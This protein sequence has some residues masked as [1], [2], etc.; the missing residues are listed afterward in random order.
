MSQRKPLVLTEELIEVG[1]KATYFEVRRQCPN[2]V[3]PDDAWQEICLKL[4]SQPQMYDSSRG[5]SEATFLKL[6][7]SRAVSKHAEKARRQKRRFRLMEIEDREAPYEEPPKKPIN[8]MQYIDCEET[9]RLCELL[10]ECNFNKSEV[11][12]QLGWSESKVRSRINLLAPRLK[13]AGVDLRTIKEQQ[14]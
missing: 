1:R 12:R 10:I 8:V 3:D 7:V 13:A 14:E 2:L 4:V 11:A 6:I 9:R 5:A